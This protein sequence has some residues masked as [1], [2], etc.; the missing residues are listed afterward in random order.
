MA[1]FTKV[2]GDYQAVMHLDSP[3]YTNNGL[4]AVTSGSVVQ[5]QG[6]KLDYFTTSASRSSTFSTTQINLIIVQ[7]LEIL[8]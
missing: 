5:P 7:S 1:Q 4:N 8:Q 3:A 2:N 6:P